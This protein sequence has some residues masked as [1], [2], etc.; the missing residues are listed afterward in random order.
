MVEMAQHQS[1]TRI[2]EACSGSVEGLGCLSN[3]QVDLLSCCLLDGT[4]VLLRA[5]EGGGDGDAP[6]WSCCGGAWEAVLPCCR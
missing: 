1:H 4:Q 3:A 2:P 6:G 5:A